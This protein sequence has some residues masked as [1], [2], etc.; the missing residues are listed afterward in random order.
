MLIERDDFSSIR[1]PALAYWWSMIFFRKWTHPGSSPGQAFSGS[2]SRREPSQPSLDRVEHEGVNVLL[3]A[4]R[5]LRHLV[6]VITALDHPQIDRR[7]HSSEHRRKL[8]RRAEGVA[9]ALHD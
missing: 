3:T 4:S 7:A 1:H 9:R 5:L 2:C 6:G 8:I